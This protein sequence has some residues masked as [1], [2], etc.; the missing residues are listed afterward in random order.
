MRCR[1]MCILGGIHVIFF[2]GEWKMHVLDV[3]S[4]IL[5][6]ALLVCGGAWV[7]VN[8]RV[9]SVQCDGK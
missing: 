2:G 8:G 9:L 4:N 6:G 5:I 1:G 3:C 7:S